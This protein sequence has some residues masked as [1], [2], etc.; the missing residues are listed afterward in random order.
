MMTRNELRQQYWQLTKLCQE[1][2][3]QGNSE[4]SDRV[5]HIREE[6]VQE[7]IKEREQ[8]ISEPFEDCPEVTSEWADMVWAEND[9]WLESYPWE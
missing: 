4:Q 8:A 3:E 9:L 2:D 7:F 1:H 5:Y 6:L